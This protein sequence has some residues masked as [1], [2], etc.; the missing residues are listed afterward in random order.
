VRSEQA[1][2]EKAARQRIRAR[3]EAEEAQELRREIAEIRSER[4]MRSPAVTS[5]T[6]H[7]VATG[8]TSF[9]R[10][11]RAGGQSVDV[12][13][14]ATLRAY[15]EHWRSALEREETMLAAVGS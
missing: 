15:G 3:R 4:A 1:D 12:A 8:P 2:I 5:G 11:N 13:M 9:Y 10:Q 7:S 14:A 6:G